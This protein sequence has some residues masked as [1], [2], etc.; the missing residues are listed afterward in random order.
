MDTTKNEKFNDS[1]FDLILHSATI[2]GDINL[3]DYNLRCWSKKY[4]YINKSPM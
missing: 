1:T 3:R 4:K 2:E